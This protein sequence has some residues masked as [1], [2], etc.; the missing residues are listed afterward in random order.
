MREQQ[1]IAI[2]KKLLDGIPRVSGN[3][4]ESLAKA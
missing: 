1:N 4:N 3:P 2:A